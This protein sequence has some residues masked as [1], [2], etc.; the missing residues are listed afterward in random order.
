M[1]G[2]HCKQT[3]IH[4]SQLPTKPV[5]AR[6]NPQVGFFQRERFSGKSLNF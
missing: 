3:P 2:K 6:K 5:G 4:V 1:A